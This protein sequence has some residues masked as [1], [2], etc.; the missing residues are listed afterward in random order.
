MF[1]VDPQTTWIDPTAGQ[2]SALVQSL[3]TPLVAAGPH[4]AENVQAWIVSRE[5]AGGSTEVAVYF[6]LTQANLPVVYRWADGAV[7]PPQLAYVQEEAL[8][9][10]ESMGFMMDNLNFGVLSPEARGELMQTLPPFTRDL[11]SLVKEMELVESSTS[12]KLDPLDDFVRMKQARA[13]A[14]QLGTGEFMSAQGDPVHEAQGDA[15]GPVFDPSVLVDRADAPNLLQPGDE[16]GDVQIEITEIEGLEL[17]SDPELVRG[18][19][20]SDPP[21]VRGSIPDPSPVASPRMMREKT[22][23]ES[24]KIFDESDFADPEPALAAA[25]MPREGQIPE[26]GAIPS[27]IGGSEMS[28]DDML[29]EVGNAAPGGDDLSSELDAI[30]DRV[31]GSNASVA[32]PAMS[33]NGNG[34]GSDDISIELS[35]PG[36]DDG[37]DDAMKMFDALVAGDDDPP[38]PAV[39]AAPS[40]MRAPAPPPISPTPSRLGRITPVAVPASEAIRAEAPV[41]PLESAWMD[42]G[43]SIQSNGSGAPGAG[44]ALRL[45]IATDDLARLL[46]ML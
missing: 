36:D 42:G 9:F 11:S 15:S 29:A 44:S 20:V 10:C 39:V 35:N 25:P 46:A 43:A 28:I 22:P 24:M 14:G 17:L 21:V 23:P 3:N 31:E 18:V 6:H 12:K 37:D 32:E 4:P 7:P 27:E 19:A 38:P 26:A 41:S 40:T 30:L 45:D 16:P 1:E 5:V 2:I 13:E 34:H 33:A 8:S